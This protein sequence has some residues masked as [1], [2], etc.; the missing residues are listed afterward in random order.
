MIFLSDTVYYID[1]NG[2]YYVS[3]LGDNF[4]N[5]IGT[6]S[7]INLNYTPYITN[8][9]FFP[10]MYI[11]GGWR[12]VKSY[13]AVPSHVSYNTFDNKVFFGNDGEEFLVSMR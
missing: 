4:I 8:K 9:K 12:V 5:N 1:K 7:I 3:S 11:N 2:N 10:M 13:L 6:V